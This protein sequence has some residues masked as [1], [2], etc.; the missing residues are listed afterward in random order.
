VVRA[1]LPKT[2]TPS[3]SSFAEPFLQRDSN[4]SNIAS[5]FIYNS[6]S[7]AKVRVD[8]AFDSTF[9]SSLFDY[10]NITQGGVANQIWSLSPAITSPP[11]CFEDYVNPAF[12]LIT[13]DLLVANNAI[14]AG[15]TYDSFAGDVTLVSSVDILPELALRSRFFI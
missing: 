1:C 10:T 5:G 13:E 2:V 14:Y 9:A 3:P 8:E 4:V 12:P 7:Q 15:M 11:Q 6:P